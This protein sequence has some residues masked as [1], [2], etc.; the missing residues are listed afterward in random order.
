MSL[1]TIAELTAAPTNDQIRTKLISFWQAAEIPITDWES[2]GV[3]RVMMELTAQ[4]LRDFM[5]TAE[6]GILGGGFPTPVDSLSSDD[7]IDLVSSQ[8]FGLTRTAASSTLQTVVLTRGAGGGGAYTI[9]AGALW[10]IGPTGNRYV[11]ITGGSLAAS[12]TLTITV[13]AESTQDTVDGRNYVDAA[14]SLTRLQD[15]LPGVTC[16]NP[17]PNF[18]AV[19]TVPT[20]AAGKGVV[21]VSGTPATSPTTYD[22]QVSMSGQRAAATIQARVNGGAWSTSVVMG[23]TY[24]FAG[25]PTVNFTDDAGGSNPSFIAGDLYSFTSPGSP[26]TVPGLDKETNTALL[27]RCFARWPDLNRT[28]RV[29]DKRLVWAKRASTAVARAR[30]FKDTVLAGVANVIIAGVTGGV[31]GGVVTAVQLYLDQHDAIGDKSV[32]ASASVTTVTP[33]GHVTVATINLAFAQAA[34]AA[35]WTAY[36][37]STDIGGV[38]ALAVLEQILMDAGA[39]DV[40]VPAGG[41]LLLNGFAV[42]LVLGSTAVATPADLI[43]NMT[44]HSI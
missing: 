10:V 39:T 40:G 6:P 42:A 19:S 22:V 31:S 29:D 13:Q 41:A 20:P 43:A 35:A 8:W 17:P 24:V 28:T 4:A 9:A 36:V 34:A 44:W 18:S 15:P 21:T 7:W 33:T 26:I 11:A 2:G 14:N 27:L 16:N 23:A 25:G 5:G 3:M 1:P 38:V 32:V 30:V 37:I 12:S